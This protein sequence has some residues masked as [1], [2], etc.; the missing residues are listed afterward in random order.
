MLRK[1]FSFRE[2]LPRHFA[3]MLRLVSRLLFSGT[4]VGK[5]GTSSLF[6]SSMLLNPEFPH[7]PEWPASLTLEEG[8][9]QR[10]LQLPNK[11]KL[12]EY[13]F[14]HSMMQHSVW[15]LPHTAIGTVSSK[16]K[17]SPVGPEGLNRPWGGNSLARKA[18]K[19]AAL[20]RRWSSTRRRVSILQATGD[21]TTFLQYEMP[22]V[23]NPNS[24]ASHKRL[25]DISIQNEIHSLCGLMNYASRVLGN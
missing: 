8:V 10:V 21:P 23:K 17:L 12:K 3:S 22:M 18:G 15:G 9:G 16:F 14:V 2:A 24:K 4:P 7:H 25:P 6:I 19:V 13:R 20:G 1:T 5:P 11:L